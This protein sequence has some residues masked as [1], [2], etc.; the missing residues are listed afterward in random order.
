MCVCVCLSHFTGSPVPQVGFELTKSLRNLEFLI[1]LILLIK[2]ERIAA[3]HR[4]WLKGCW[5]LSQ[6]SMHTRPTHPAD[7]SL[8]SVPEISLKILCF[9]CTGLC[10]TRMQC[11]QTPAEG[12]ITQLELDLEKV[13]SHPV[14]LV[15]EAVASGRA[16][17]LNH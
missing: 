5:G 17:L 1:L 16:V 9:G 12:D 8:A 15:I 7:R 3:Y 6:D 10:T 2:A 14:V 11:P 13:L 4:A